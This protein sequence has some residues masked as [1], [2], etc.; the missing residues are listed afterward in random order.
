MYTLTEE[1]LTAIFQAILWIKQEAWMTLPSI[2]GIHGDYNNV[3]G[4]SGSAC[5][6]SLESLGV[7]V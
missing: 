7:D 5:I 6:R 1:K 3:V 4:V 2:K